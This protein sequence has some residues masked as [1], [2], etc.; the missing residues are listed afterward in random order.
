MTAKLVFHLTVA[1]TLGPFSASFIAISRNTVS[2]L[3]A[4][5][6][7]HMHS[8]SSCHVSS[9]LYTSFQ[10]SSGVACLL[11]HG[12]LA[13]F[14]PRFSLQSQ[15]SSYR[16]NSAALTFSLANEMPEW[17]GRWLLEEIFVEQSKRHGLNTRR[18]LWDCFAGEEDRGEPCI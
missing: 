15:C 18:R 11:N 14:V 4:L 10:G 7:P 17:S 12:F 16:S 13:R 8:P 2:K 9:T 5:E 1:L 6:S 3:E